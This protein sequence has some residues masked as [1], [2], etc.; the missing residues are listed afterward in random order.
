[1]WFINPPP[2][3][4]E[5]DYSENPTYIAGKTVIVGWTAPKQGAGVSLV[6]YQLN[7]TDGMWYGDGE[8]L[9]RTDTSFYPVGSRDITDL[10]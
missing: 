5:G 6:L 9:T 3:G 1:M 7:K 4:T 2:F 10:P 8:Y